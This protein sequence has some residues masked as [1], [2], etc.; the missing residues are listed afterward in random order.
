MA[1]WFDGRNDQIFMGRL[2]VPA[3]TTQFTMCGWFVTDKDADMYIINKASGTRT[4]NNTWTLAV[5]SSQRL[6]GRLKINGTTTEIKVPNT[7]EVEFDKLHH[8]AMTYDGSQIKLYLDGVLRVTAARTGDVTIDTNDV[9]IGSR[10]NSARSREWRGE[11]SDIRIYTRALTEIDVNN[12]IAS[13]GNDFDTIG[14]IHR[15]PLREL[16]DG[17]VANTTVYDIVGGANGTS[18]SSPYYKNDIIR[19]S[20]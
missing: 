16:E 15:W 1:L 20:R 8:G 4:S 9:A 13:Q 6:Y 10:A 17:T 12:I 19:H 14:L 18:L 3:N 7:G 11:L 2:D 5:D